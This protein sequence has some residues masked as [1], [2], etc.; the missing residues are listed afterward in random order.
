MWGNEGAREEI[1]KEK[2]NGA[3]DNGIF[4]EVAVVGGDEDAN[5]VGHDETDKTD[6]AV[7]SD[8]RCRS[9]GG[10]HENDFLCAFDIDAKLGGLFL[11]KLKCVEG[12]SEKVEND[13]ANDEIWES[14]PDS[15]PS[16]IAGSA[17][18][19]CDGWFEIRIHEEKDE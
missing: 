17:K 2:N 4:D 13:D 3:I 7:E 9:D 11:T 16:G 8:S 12:V 15:L 18:E 19:K 5:D 14:N 6:D 1:G 10:G